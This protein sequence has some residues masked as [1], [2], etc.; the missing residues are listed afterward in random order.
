VSG[1]LAGRVALV[2]G[3]ARNIGR[4][5]ALALAADGAAVAVNTRRSAEAAEAVAAEIR[6]GGGRAIAVLADVTDRAAVEAMLARVREALG[7]LDILVNNA[8][9]RDEAPFEALSYDAWREAFAATLDGAFHV[10][11]AALPDLLRSEAGAVINIGGLTGHT[12]APHRAHVVAAKAGL[13]GFTR[14]LAHEFSPRGV[15]VNCVVPGLIATEREGGPPKHRAARTTLAGRQG[16][17]S[18]IAA[19]VRWLAGPGGRYVTGQS[20]HI[21]GGLLMAG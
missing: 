19:A 17:P 9:V 16:A 21:N 4:E 15:M 1:P 11:Q 7:P 2:T 6:A 20:I 14:A 8:A 3:A 12:G 18:D 5:I 13:A 10:T